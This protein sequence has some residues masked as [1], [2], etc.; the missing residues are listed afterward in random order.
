MIDENQMKR[1]LEQVS[2]DIGFGGEINA[3]VSDEAERRLLNTK[4]GCT[5]AEMLAKAQRE[6]SEDLARQ[7]A[8]EYGEEQC[9]KQT[10]DL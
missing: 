9:R 10:G 5:M 8:S 4:P 1:F 7:S 2:I 3:E 6:T